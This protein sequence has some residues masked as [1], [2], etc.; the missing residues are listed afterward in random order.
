[1]ARV[2][3]R[4]HRSTSHRELALGSLF[5]LLALP[6]CPMTDDYFIDEAAGDSGA[7]GGSGG[8]GPDGK[9]GKEPKGTGGS[10]GF[11]GMTGGISGTG[12]DIGTGGISGSGGDGGSGGSSTDGWGKT[13]PPPGGFSPRE[14]AGYASIGSQLFIWGGVNESGTALNSGALY[15]PRD[16]RWVVVASDAN[17]PTPR[18]LPSAVWT[19]SVI[20]V[21]GGFDPVSMQPLADGAIYDPVDDAWSAMS[22]GPMARAGA[23]GVSSDDRVVFFGGQDESG[24]LSGLDVYDPATDTWEPGVA[25]S[26]PAAADPAAAGGTLTFWTYGGRTSMNT[27]VSDMSYWSMSSAR[28]VSSEPLEPGR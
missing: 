17:T 8:S 27:G 26:P 14:K 20:V 25:D 2:R 12:G 6:G 10:A 13:S 23:L 1:M 18:S 9:A 11:A 22:S 28:W 4:L 5:A 24:P 16:D 19:G 3:T 21:W 7:I 15:N